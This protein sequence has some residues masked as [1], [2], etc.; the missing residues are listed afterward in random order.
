MGLSRLHQIS[1][2]LIANGKD[3]YTP[4]AVIASGTTAR[5]RCV[6]GEL[7]SIAAISEKAD[8][9][10]P[11]ILVVGDVVNLNK[12]IDWQQAGPFPGRK[13]L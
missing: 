12:E 10:P 9:Q 4:A 11:A 8:I 6:T 3:A 5:Q 7:S 13:F 2:R 1:E